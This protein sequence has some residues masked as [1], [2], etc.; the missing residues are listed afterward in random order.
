MVITSFWAEA[1]LRRLNERYTTVQT[2]DAAEW[3]RGP[4][5]R[6]RV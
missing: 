5:L 6:N 3:D 2:K 1:E 4:S